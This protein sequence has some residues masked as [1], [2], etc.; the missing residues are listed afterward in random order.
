M[1]EMRERGND[2]EVNEG[3]DEKLKNKRKILDN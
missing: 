2:L 3:N 1:R